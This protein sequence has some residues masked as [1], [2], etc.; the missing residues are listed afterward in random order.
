MM[1]SCLFTHIEKIKFSVCLGSCVSHLFGI[2]VPS[3]QLGPGVLA[4]H[5]K[6]LMT[7]LMQLE[8]QEGWKIAV[9]EE[10]TY[11]VMYTDVCRGRQNVRGNPTE[12]AIKAM[13]GRTG[14]LQSCDMV[15]CAKEE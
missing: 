7:K 1:S 8:S 5:S 9:G 15:H 3:T 12:R 4:I 14:V 11:S 10:L 6:D 2:P 13:L